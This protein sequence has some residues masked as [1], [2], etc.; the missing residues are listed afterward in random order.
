MY[1][2]QHPH[3]AA[4]TCWCCEV[5][6]VCHIHC[7]ARFYHP[8]SRIE[9]PL[10]QTLV[11]FIKFLSPFYVNQRFFSACAR[12][13]EL[14]RENTHVTATRIDNTHAGGFFFRCGT[15]SNVVM[16]TTLRCPTGT[17]Q[18]VVTRTASSAPFYASKQW[19][20]GDFHPCATL[21][22]GAVCTLLRC[23]QS[24]VSTR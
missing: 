5:T 22:H 21:P 3:C 13:P 10:A 1:V 14:R 20:T 12:P 15:Q 23:C 7:T 11:F 6:G 16:A 18:C 4:E 9:S 8:A 19:R 2:A 24:T 17:P